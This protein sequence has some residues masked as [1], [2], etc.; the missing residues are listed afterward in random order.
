MAFAL[1]AAVASPAYAGIPVFDAM[2]FASNVVQN[3]QLAKIHYQLKDQGQGTVIYNTNNIDNSTKKIDHSTSISAKYD[4]RNYEINQNFKWVIKLGE[5]GEEIIPIPR[6]VE[7]KLI[8]MFG[9]SDEAAYDSYA[10]KF[11]DA[12][13]YMSPGFSGNLGEAPSESSRARKA[14]ND[15]LVR[16]IHA[17]QV[18]LQEEVEGFA[19]LQ[20][21]GKTV[22]GQAQQ[23]Q[24]ANALAGSQINQ[25][26]KMRNAM[27][28]SDAQRVA[29][30]QAAADREARAIAVGQRMR[31]GLDKKVAVGLVPA[32]A[33]P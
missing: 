23:M 26:A 17:E 4:Q 19:A 10:K 18:A 7:N 13:H 21:L 16:S 20:E 6:D 5:G 25:L 30:S 29:E 11:Q 3:I 1:A 27:L 32:V 31:M 33:A 8:A 28:V 14:A 9:G 15:L 24:L 12:D 2:N 22:E